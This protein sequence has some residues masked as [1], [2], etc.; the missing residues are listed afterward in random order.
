MRFFMRIKLFNK[1]SKN[2]IVRINDTDQITMASMEL[3]EIIV[4]QSDEI[5]ASVRK[6]EDSY[7]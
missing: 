6:E 7:L 2:I 3:R 5:L 1:S 4:P